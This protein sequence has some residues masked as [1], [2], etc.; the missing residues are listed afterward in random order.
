MCYHIWNDNKIMLIYSD[1]FFLFL[2]TL[3]LNSP[4]SQPL[5]SKCFFPIMPLKNKTVF[6]SS[7]HSNLSISITILH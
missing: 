5:T 3:K 4:S 2:V 1:F 6:R 7:A